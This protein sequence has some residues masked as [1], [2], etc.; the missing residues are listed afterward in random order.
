MLHRVPYAQLCPAT[1][2]LQWLHLHIIW[3]FSHWCLWHGGISTENLHT[4]DRLLKIVFIRMVAIVV[5]FGTTITGMHTFLNVSYDIIYCWFN[6]F[7]IYG[8]S[9]YV[10]TP[11]EVILSWRTLLWFVCKPLIFDKLLNREPLNSAIINTLTS[12]CWLIS[13]NGTQVNVY[14]IYK[15]FVTS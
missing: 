12:K 6:S 10:N 4:A 7:S 1:D 5:K 15:R 3:F 11:F 14:P 13:W 2:P 8:N 9:H